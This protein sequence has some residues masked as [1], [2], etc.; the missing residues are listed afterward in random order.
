MCLGHKISGGAKKL[1]DQD[2][3]FN[4]ILK[5]TS[6]QKIQDE[7][8]IKIFNKNS[9]TDISFYLKLQSILSLH[10]FLIYLSLKSE[11]MR[12]AAGIK[13]TEIDVI[14]QRNEM[15]TK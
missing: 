5:S 13:L 11:E 15:W 6:A 10:C 8:T 2:A 1:S 3:Y 14:N 4:A 9:M 7:Q 12:E